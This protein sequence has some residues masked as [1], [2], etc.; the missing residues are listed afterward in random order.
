M[1]YVMSGLSNPL[2]R[3]QVVNAEG[4]VQD[5]ELSAEE[6]AELQRQD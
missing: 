6:L 2:N 4:V 5:V 1:G 3:E